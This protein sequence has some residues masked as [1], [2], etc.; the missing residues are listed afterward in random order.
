VKYEENLDGKR[1]EKAQ[2]RKEKAQ[3]TEESLFGK[4]G[5]LVTTSL[6]M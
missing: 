4:F 2:E 3:K 5:L 6:L 1:K